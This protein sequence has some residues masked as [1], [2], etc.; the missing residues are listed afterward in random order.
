[1]H[2]GLHVS[3]EFDSKQALSS[4]ETLTGLSFRW[5]SVSKQGRAL[6]T[7]LVVCILSRKPG[8]DPGTVHV[9]FAINKVALL[10]VFLQ[11][12]FG[13]GSHYLQNYL[14]ILLLSER[15]AGEEL[16][17]SRK[18]MLFRS[19]E[20]PQTKTFHVVT[21]QRDNEDSNYIKRGRIC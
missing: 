3:S 4:D 14:I 20:A 10:Q 8:F 19:Y 9:R 6:L 21:I 15:R 17:T 11:V 13:F 12:Y 2:S 16:E 18:A 5:R 7:P 1:M